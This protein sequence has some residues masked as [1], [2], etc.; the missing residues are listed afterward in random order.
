[1]SKGRLHVLV[2]GRVLNTQRPF[3]V[4]R[5]LAKVVKL[6]LQAYRGFE[7]HSLSANPRDPLF[8]E[9]SRVSGWAVLGQ[10]G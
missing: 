1:M 3:A 8:C 6:L 7:S 4:S 10:F 2:A 5:N 9:G